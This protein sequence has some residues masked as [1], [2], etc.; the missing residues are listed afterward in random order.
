M[1]LS[2]GYGRSITGDDEKE[3][4]D[5][6]VYAEKYYRHKDDKADED[7]S[8]GDLICENEPVGTNISNKTAVDDHIYTQFGVEWQVDNAAE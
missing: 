1:L 5:C 6:P 7:Y 3:A 4:C 8:N 2:F